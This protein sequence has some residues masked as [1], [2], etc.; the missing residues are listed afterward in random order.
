LSWFRASWSFAGWNPC[1]SRLLPSELRPG[2]FAGPLITWMNTSSLWWK[3]YA[4]LWPKRVR[5]FKNRLSWALKYSYCELS[6]N[7]L[8]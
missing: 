3:T 7:K 5:S 6:D 2:I 8:N 1:W 4:E